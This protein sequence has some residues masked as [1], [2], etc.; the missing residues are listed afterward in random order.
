MLFRSADDESRED[1]TYL[2]IG[3]PISG[4]HLPRGHGDIDAVDIGDDADEK[5]Q[6]ENEPADS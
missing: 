1:P 5:Q 6:D 4:H 3:H 2:L